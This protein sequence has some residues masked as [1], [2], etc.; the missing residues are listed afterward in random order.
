MGTPTDDLPSFLKP[1]Q[2]VN[3][4][5]RVARLVLRVTLPLCGWIVAWA[6]NDMA[7]RGVPF[8]WQGLRWWFSLWR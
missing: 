2:P 1:S 5:R 6:L 4:V 7:Y 3:G 8:T